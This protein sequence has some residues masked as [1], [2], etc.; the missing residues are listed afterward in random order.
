MHV[1]SS[2]HGVRSEQ[3]SIREKRIRVSRIVCGRIKAVLR[4]GCMGDAKSRFIRSDIDISRCIII[5]KT[6]LSNCRGRHIKINEK[7]FTL[8]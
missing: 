7:L 5:I 2:L 6:I 3:G 1:F 4:A 8:A